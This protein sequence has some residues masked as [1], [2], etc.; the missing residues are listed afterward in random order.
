MT[1]TSIP[2]VPVL[3]T[4]WERLSHPGGPAFPVLPLLHP[5]LS[6]ALPGTPKLPPSWAA[7]KLYL[8]PPYTS[9]I[10][11][12]WI[13][14]GRPFGAVKMCRL[15]RVSPP[16][17]LPWQYHDR[18]GQLLATEIFLLSLSDGIDPLWSRLW[19]LAVWRPLSVSTA[20]R[21]ASWQTCW[22]IP[23]AETGRWFNVELMPSYLQDQLLE[24]HPNCFIITKK[25]QNLN[26]PSDLSILQ[27]LFTSI[28]DLCFLKRTFLF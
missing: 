7:Q 26:F 6:G 24:D 14:W 22:R 13:S 21:S 9:S 25:V 1:T 3:A 20:S 23:N 5:C 2:A 10:A 27:F 11:K 19:C 18:R 12:S 16:Q 4:E 15:T 28:L 17:V 8:K